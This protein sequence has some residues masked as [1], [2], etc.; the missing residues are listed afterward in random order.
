MSGDIF[1]HMIAVKQKY[2]MSASFPMNNDNLSGH[3]SAFPLS[4]SPGCKAEN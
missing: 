1:I 4:H 2:A 3:S